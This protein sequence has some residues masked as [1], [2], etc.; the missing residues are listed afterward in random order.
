MQL[1]QITIGELEFLMG[2]FPLKIVVHKQILKYF[3]CLRD[4]NENTIVKEAFI[5]SE[6]LWEKGHKNIHSYV[7]SIQNINNFNQNILKKSKHSENLTKK[8]ITYFIEIWRNSLSNS[9]KLQLYSRI[10]SNHEPER[11]LNVIKKEKLRKSLT[12]LRVSNQILMIEQGRYQNPQ[13]FREHRF[14]P[15]CFQNV[16]ESFHPF[17]Q[18]LRIAFH[19]LKR[20]EG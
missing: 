4:L 7:D 10:K 19:P 11:Y 20:M 17:L 16:S 12:K 5:L 6:K 3:S 2:R 15:I 14:C 18:V 9:R 13:L 8:M 1:I